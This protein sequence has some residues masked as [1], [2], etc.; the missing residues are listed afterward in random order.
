MRLRSSTNREEKGC[1]CVNLYGLE[2]EQRG[3]GWGIP[4][5]R[6]QVQP[7]SHQELVSTLVLATATPIGKGEL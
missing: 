7:L 1:S 5:C 6:L 3:A 4:K 2:Q